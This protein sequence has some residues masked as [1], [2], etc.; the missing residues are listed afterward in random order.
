MWEADYVYDHLDRRVRSEIAYFDTETQDP[1]G[2]GL[3]VTETF[4]SDASQVIRVVNDNGHETL[5][6]FDADAT[7]AQ[8]IFTFTPPFNAERLRFIT[9]EISSSGADSE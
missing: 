3:S 1:I 2:D 8:D 5:V 6:S 9:D 4:Y 7:I